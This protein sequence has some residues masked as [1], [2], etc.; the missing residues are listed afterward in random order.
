MLELTGKCIQTVLITAFHMFKKLCRDMKYIFKKN[1][2]ELLK[3]KTMKCEMK[4]TW[5]E[6]NSRLDTAE[7]MVSELLSRRT[8]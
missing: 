7:K 1:Q 2:T 8:I 3:M 4:N 5:N 6:N